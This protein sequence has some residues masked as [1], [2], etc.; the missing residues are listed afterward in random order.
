MMI[1]TLLTIVGKRIKLHLS[2]WQPA[3][4]GRGNPRMFCWGLCGHKVFLLSD[5]VIAQRHGPCPNKVFWGFSF[6]TDRTPPVSKSLHGLR[7]TEHRRVDNPRYSRPAFQRGTGEHVRY[8]GETERT[9]KES[10]APATLDG[11]QVRPSGEGEPRA[12]PLGM[13]CPIDFSL[14]DVRI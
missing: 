10:L 6:G 14:T 2:V 11:H 5:C 12:S 13:L 9:W 8:S 7:G 3:E 4:T 1:I